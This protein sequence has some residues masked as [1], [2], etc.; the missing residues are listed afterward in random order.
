MNNAKGLVSGKPT[1]S[2]MAIPIILFFILKMFFVE[3]HRTHFLSGMLQIVCIKHFP[4]CGETGVCGEGTLI[5]FS[6]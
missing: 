6:I 2:P 5:L 1:I 4:S 3:V